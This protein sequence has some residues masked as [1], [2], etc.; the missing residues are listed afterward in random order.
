M[1]RLNKT[2]P[3]PPQTRRPSSQASGP[4]TGPASAERKNPSGRQLASP[5]AASSSST[6]TGS[7]GDAA[8]PVR[9]RQV[10]ARRLDFLAAP[11]GPGPFEQQVATA[12]A[13]AVRGTVSPAALGVGVASALTAQPDPARLRLD[14]LWSHYRARASQLSPEHL[15]DLA[16]TVGAHLLI[17]CADAPTAM[18]RGLAELLEPV[19]PYLSDRQRSG[20]L[21]GLDKACAAMESF[22]D[23]VQAELRA[24][25]G[26]LSDHAPPEAKSVRTPPPGQGAGLGAESPARSPTR[27]ALSRPGALDA[28]MKRSPADVLMVPG[29]NHAR[30]LFL[31]EEALR[32]EP[33]LGAARLC[34]QFDRIASIGSPEQQPQALLALLT[35]GALVLEPGSLDARRL[36]PEVFE[37]LTAGAL[38]KV[39]RYCNEQVDIAITHSEQAAQLARWR[40]PSGDDET[41]IETK[42]SPPRRVQTRLE[43][44]L[45][46]IDARLQVAQQAAIDQAVDGMLRF[47]GWFAQSDSLAQGREAGRVAPAQRAFVAGQVAALR[48]LAPQWPAEHAV[49]VLA[50]AAALDKALG[51]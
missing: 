37:Q 41:L 1:E 32:R 26:L 34:Q 17:T 5:S 33:A 14:A 21:A 38:L 29:L 27:K 13:G 40:P 45:R 2:P 43:Q 10:T 49:V 51:R 20:L 19:A 22:P 48:Q 50:V 4:A 18:A 16:L 25:R 15:Q 31:L 12:L 6:S 46:S 11:V 30:R 39:A 47:Y 9:T 23:A 7:P 8:P 42:T 28:L 24:A 3:T 35:Q 44:D 36:S